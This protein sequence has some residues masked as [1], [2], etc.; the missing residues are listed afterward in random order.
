[1]LTLTLT[2]VD[3]AKVSSITVNGGTTGLTIYE[4][5]ADPLVAADDIDDEDIGHQTDS[6]R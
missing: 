4:G 5:F 2:A 1:M 3:D 6:P